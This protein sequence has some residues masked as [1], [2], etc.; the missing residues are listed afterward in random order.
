MIE[1]LRKK[2]KKEVWNLINNKEIEGIDDSFFIIVVLSILLENESFNLE[3]VMSL[4]EKLKKAYQNALDR[5]NKLIIEDY[6]EI[7]NILKEVF[8]NFDIEA[9]QIIDKLKK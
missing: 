2:L 4:V 6:G 8:Q 9:K 1:D 3:E 5:T 7:I